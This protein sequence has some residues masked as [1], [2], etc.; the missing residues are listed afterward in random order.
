MRVEEFDVR[1]SR[2]RALE[3]ERARD[4][5][6]EIVRRALE[7][8]LRARDEAVHLHARA[9][10]R[11]EVVRSARLRRRLERLEARQREEPAWPPAASSSRSLPKRGEPVREEPSASLDPRFQAV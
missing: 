10:I 2:L 1:S 4:D 11:R 6:V 9:E 8:P 7:D 5:A 3:L